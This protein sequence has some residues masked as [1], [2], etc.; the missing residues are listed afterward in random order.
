MKAKLWHCHNSRS[1]RVLWALEELNIDYDLEIM[2]FPPRYKVENYKNL[3]SLGTVPYFVDGDTRMTESSAICHYLAEKEALNKSSTINLSVNVKHPEYGNYLNWLYHSDATLTFPQTL[4]LRYKIFAPE[5]NDQQK[6]AEDYEKW[7]ATR[8][9]RLDEHLEG[10][11][12]LCDNRFTMA[13]ITIGYALFLGKLLKLDS[14]YSDN[15]MA[16]LTR[17]TQR[18]AFK[19]AQAIGQEQPSFSVK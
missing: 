17:I 14:H 6:T 8:L 9:V 10:R 18:Q 13:D 2:P 15:I 12:Y 4:V 11:E 3:N 19:I 7:F 5:D 16:Y 1:L